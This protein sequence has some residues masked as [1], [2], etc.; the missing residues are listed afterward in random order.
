MAKVRNPDRG[1]NGNDKIQERH[2]GTTHRIVDEDTSPEDVHGSENDP[3]SPSQRRSPD[4]FPGLSG[5]DQNRG[6]RSNLASEFWSQG[7]A[8]WR[9]L[10]SRPSGNSKVSD[11]TPQVEEPGN[12]P[13]D[14]DTTELVPAPSTD[15]SH[16]SKVLFSLESEGTSASS[17]GVEHPARRL[18]DPPVTMLDET[19]DHQNEPLRSSAQNSTETLAPDVGTR[20]QSLEIEAQKRCNVPASAPNVSTGSR[21]GEEHDSLIDDDAVSLHAG[22]GESTTTS[23][24]EAESDLQSPALT[25]NLYPAIPIGPMVGD[26]TSPR[27]GQHSRAFLPKLRR[28][29]QVWSE[30]SQVSEDNKSSSAEATSHLSE[31]RCVTPVSRSKNHRLQRLKSLSAEAPAFHPS[32]PAS[33]P[34]TPTRP[35]GNGHGRSASL[36]TGQS[37]TSYSSAKP[38]TPLGQH[39]L[40]PSRQSSTGTPSVS[41]ESGRFTNS[42]GVSHPSIDRRYPKP[43]QHTPE[44]QGQFFNTPRSTP[45]QMPIQNSQSLDLNAPPSLS[46]MRLLNYNT[47]RYNAHVYQQDE[48][49]T[50]YSQSNHFDSYAT[51]QA[52]SAAPNSSDVHQNGSIYTQDT[53]GYGP[54]YYPNHTDPSHQVEFCLLRIDYAGLIKIQLN[55]HLYTP[56]EPHREPSKP[57][58][59]AAKDLFIPEDIRLKLQARTEATLRVFAGR[60]L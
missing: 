37:D 1:S 57:N 34:T 11:S 22:H 16:R 51:S 42:G 8:N 17:S 15:H 29:P 3:Y 30:P 21:G 36:Q 43:H 50:D 23:H 40:W 39:S 60:H 41:V 56:L 52:A 14:R 12:P 10:G 4:G 59:R 35:Y 18:P 25:G 13:T 6:P 7:V 9:G 32:L 54:R 28:H 46:P 58:Q 24:L 49:N 55:H 53:N 33:L 48:Q 19:P 38:N 47:P 20:D 44:G 26:G 2:Q 31:P 5:K 45:F 27:T